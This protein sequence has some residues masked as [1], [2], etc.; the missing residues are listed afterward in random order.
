MLLTDGVE[1]WPIEEVN[2]FRENY[3]K[4]E[5]SILHKIFLQLL[6]FR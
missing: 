3:P 4:E 2:R 6:F 1:F 5:V